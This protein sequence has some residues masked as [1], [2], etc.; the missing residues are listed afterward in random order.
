MSFVVRPVVPQADSWQLAFVASLALHDTV[1]RLGLDGRVKWPNDVL[2]DDRKIAG[3]LV[4]TGAAGGAWFAIAGIGVNVR[5]SEFEGASEYVHP[6]ISLAMAG[7]NAEI[8]DIITCC[9][10]RL[11]DR[12]R[13][14]CAG[15]WPNILTAWRS[16]QAVGAVVT[17]GDQR[18]AQVDVDDAGMVLV[19]L[20][21]GTFARWTS[22]E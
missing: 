8:G 10:D 20:P 13:E 22:V 16:A 7:V 15:G 6:P 1:A 14:W 4:E 2:V 9:A 17:K 11:G 18:G 19:K 3:I 12:V 21:D 5:Q